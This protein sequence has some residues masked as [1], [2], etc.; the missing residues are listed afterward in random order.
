MTY[1]YSTLTERHY[2]EEIKLLFFVSPKVDINVFFEFTGRV[3]TGGA[4]TSSISGDRSSY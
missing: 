4:I 1:L 2:L 3:S